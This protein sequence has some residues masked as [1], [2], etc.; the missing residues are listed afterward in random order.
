MEL[1]RK[2]FSR[3]DELLPYAI[4]VT[5]NPLFSNDAADDRVL[6][7]DSNLSFIGLYLQ[8]KRGRKSRLGRS[9]HLGTDN[10]IYVADSSEKL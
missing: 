3:V 9:V 7:F 6:E 2:W 5:Q 8:R 4:D 10:R 1:T